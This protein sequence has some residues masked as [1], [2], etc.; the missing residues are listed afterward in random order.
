MTLNAI[1][2]AVL[3]SFV[4]WSDN[5]EFL[6]GQTHRRRYNCKHLFSAVETQRSIL[7]FVFTIPSEIDPGSEITTALPVNTLCTIQLE[8][9]RYTIALLANC[10]W[11][12]ERFCF[13]VFVAN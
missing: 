7:T 9:A 3:L 6:A 10:S 2:V 5:V 8:L 12:H 4:I 11:L 13:H 1:T